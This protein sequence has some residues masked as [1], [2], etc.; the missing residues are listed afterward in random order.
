MDRGGCAKLAR[1]VTF[2]EVC[3]QQ[4]GKDREL[5]RCDGAIRMTAPCLSERTGLCVIE[6]DHGNVPL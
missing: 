6:A 4:G 3:E 2:S 1:C 5:R